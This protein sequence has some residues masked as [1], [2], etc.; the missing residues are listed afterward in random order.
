MNA[1]ARPH[2]ARSTRRSTPSSRC[3]IA[4]AC[5]RRP[6][7]AT[8]Q[9][10]RGEY[11]RLDAR[12]PA[13][14]QGSDRDQ[15][16]P[17]HAGSRIFKD[18]VPAADAI[19][20]ERM[21]RAGGIIIGKTNTPEFGLGS[22]HLQRRVRPHAQRLRPDQDRRA[23]RAAAPASRSRCACCRSPT[24]AI[25]AA[26]CA[27][28]A[29]FNNVFGFRPSYGRVPAQGLDVFYACDG[30]AG[31]DGAHRARPRH[32]AVGAGRLR[33]APAAVEPAGPGAVR[34]SR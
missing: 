14:G 21:K 4:A 5:S 31:A 33:P 23:D 8:P 34:A 30:R 1:Y 24:A 27:I 16:H 20:V 29:A 13:R 22:Q 10:A 15:G 28:P 19:V 2:R 17:H 32:A 12:L 6:M 18:F 3:R 7:R 25:T 9:L 11:L 26:R